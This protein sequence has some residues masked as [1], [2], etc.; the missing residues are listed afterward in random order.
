MKHK[1][2]RYGLIFIWATLYL[3][4]ISLFAKRVKYWNWNSPGHCYKIPPD[5][6]SLYAILLPRGW[7]VHGSILV[8]IGLLPAIGVGMS[9]FHRGRIWY[10]ARAGVLLVAAAQGPLH[11]YSIFALRSSN[12]AFLTSGATEQQ[13]GLGQTVPMILL[14]TNITALMNGIQGKPNCL[15]GCLDFAFIRGSKTPS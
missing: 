7:V 3:A 13:W 1:T 14:G 4:Y 10:C 9:L 6:N 15:P 2:Q 12:E 11:A 8:F 5:N